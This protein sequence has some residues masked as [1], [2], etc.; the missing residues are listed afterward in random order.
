MSAWESDEVAALFKTEANSVWRLIVRIL[1][2]D[3]H[4]ASDCFQQSFVELV[5]RRQ[6]LDDVR[7]AASLL[8]RIAAARAIDAIRRRIRERRRVQDVDVA[9]VPSDNGDEPE[10]RT[11]FSELVQSL[12]IA[13]A[14]LPEQQATAF[15]LTQIEEMSHETAAAAM[16]VTATNLGVLLHRARAFLRRRLV[17]HRPAR[18][19]QP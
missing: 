5:A 10:A 13:L 2:N 14:E 4:D 7:H 9:L 17:S 15:V 8:K 3:G 19:A 16:G 11:E 1:G 18:E 6:R 12:R